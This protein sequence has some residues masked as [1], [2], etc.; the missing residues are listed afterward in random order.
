MDMIWSDKKVPKIWMLNCLVQRFH[1]L[2]MVKVDSPLLRAF[3]SQLFGEKNRYPAYIN[4]F[5]YWLFNYL[6]RRNPYIIFDYL[7]FCLH[8]KTKVHESIQRCPIDSR[9]PLYRFLKKIIKHD[10]CYNIF[11]FRAIYLTGGC[12]L[13]RGLTER[14]EFEVIFHHFL[15]NDLSIL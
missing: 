5:D 4:W 3:S 12:S 8:I 2:L 14:L 13:L 10:K 6:S 7:S 11:L 9:R 1:L 15:S